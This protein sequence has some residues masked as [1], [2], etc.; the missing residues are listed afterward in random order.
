MSENVDGRESVNRTGDGDDR[1]ANLATSWPVQHQFTGV[2]MAL[3]DRQLVA[4]H[5]SSF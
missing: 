3:G 5:L 2:R 4:V 1:Q